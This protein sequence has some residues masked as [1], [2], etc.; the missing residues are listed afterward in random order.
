MS[1]LTLFN[2]LMTVLVYMGAKKLAARIHS[3]FTT[4]ILTA[5]V[6]VIAILLLMDVNYSQYEHAKAWMTYMLGPATVALAVPMYKNRVLIKEN[7]RNIGAGLVAGSISTIVS[8]VLIAKLFHLSDE[9]QAAAAVKAITTPVA[10]D[11]VRIIGGDPSLAAVFVITAGIFGAAFGPSILTIC[12]I[13]DPVSRGL[14]I[15]T[16]S[17]G[18]GTSEI[19]NEG[20]IQGGVSSIAMSLAA[21]FTSIILP[22]IYPFIS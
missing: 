1:G 19:V 20:S 8:A 15:G 5:T 17:H 16:V 9:I 11:T 12:R 2:I 18:I 4:P 14:A 22:W 3:P 6:A 10:V 21:I 13:S 7:L